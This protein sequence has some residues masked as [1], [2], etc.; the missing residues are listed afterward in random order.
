MEFITDLPWVNG[1]GFILVVVDQLTKMAHFIPCSK[2]IITK[3][4]SQLVLDWIFLLYDLPY[5]IISIKGP[6]FASKFWQHMFK[7]FTIDIWFST[8]FHS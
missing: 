1:K 6:Q 5:K 2:T 4:T 7:F 3:E 8:T